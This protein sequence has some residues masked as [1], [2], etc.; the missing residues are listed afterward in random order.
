MKSASFLLASLSLAAV[1]TSSACTSQNLCSKQA[2]CLSEEEDIDLEADSTSVC[3]AEFD[4][5]IAA[6]RANEEDDCQKLADA[7]VALAACKS[8]LK[9]DDFFEADL[10]GECDDQLDD[11]EDARNDA[12]GLT[13]TAQD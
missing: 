1:V 3:V 13:C 5:Q 4:G 6:L 11:F 8:G 10:G 12:D 9:C 2:Q 7:T